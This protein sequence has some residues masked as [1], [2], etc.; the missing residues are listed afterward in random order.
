LQAQGK[1]GEA[2]KAFAMATRVNPNF[3][4]AHENLGVALAEQ[5]RFEP[6]I[7]AYRRVLELR[8][9]SPEAHNNIGNAFGSMGQY[10]RA[11]DYLRRAIELRFD[12]PN[13]H[14]NLAVALRAV[15][16]FDEALAE[17]RQAIRLQPDFAGAHFNSGQLLLLMGRFDEGWAEYEWRWKLAHAALKV[18]TDRPQWNGEDLA[19]KT[20]LLH[21][22]QGFGDAMQFVR[23]A[24]D[25]A[26]RGGRVILECQ[27]RLVRL[28]SGLP[29]VSQVIAQGEARPTTDVHCPL[30]SL[31]RVF[32]VTDRSPLWRGAYLKTPE[33]IRERWRERVAEAVEK[34]RHPSTSA[35]PALRS[36]SEPA[37]GDLCAPLKV[38]V[39]WAGNPRNEHDRE[40]SMS[41]ALL[42]P[43]AAVPNIAWFSLQKDAAA[44]AA[45]SRLRLIDLTGD[46][47]D[48]ADSAA[49]I[50]QL[51]L[52][53]TVDTA[54]AHL[55]GAMGKPVWLML[56]KVPDFRWM[57]DRP[58]TP[59]YPT[60]RLFR[61]ESAGDWAGVVERIRGELAT[62]RPAGS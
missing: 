5:R 28:M 24:T 36:P 10:D 12:Y 19:G 53:I 39:A 22:E 54:V 34:M 11:M 49:L 13:A 18:V 46:P 14:N 2:I 32:K 56:P 55:A 31:A 3:A 45:T 38:G 48:W 29:G 17:Y 26:E 60:M 61:Q 59:W 1:L 6:A 41:L 47:H 8:P 51:D 20:I 4:D 43:L 40:R 62:Y 27:P 44:Q 35:D 9:Q 16:K 42:D 57:L 52:V 30:L 21:A 37:S 15:G 58:D 7:A 23:F 50:E 33:E 25:V